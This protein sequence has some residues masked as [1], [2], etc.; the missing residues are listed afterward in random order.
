MN[1]ENN[2]RL[3]RL[4]PNGLTLGRL[5]LTVVFL[6]MVLYAP[7]KSQEK[8]ATFLMVAFTLFVVAGVTDMVDGPVAR[9]LN[10][11]S[12]FGRMVDP[13]ADKILVGGAFI[14]FAIVKQPT[15]LNIFS[16][17]TASVIQWATAIIIIAREVLVTILRHIA[18]ARGVSFAATATGKIKMFVQSFGIGTVMVKWAFVSRSW[19]DWFTVVTFLIMLTVT[20]VS[21]VSSLRRPRG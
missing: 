8:P 11:T 4:I 16:P 1:G 21:G 13:L 12:K 5:I 6:V 20:V 17:I 7:Q 15:F 3:V 18:E 10:V 2:N 9:A 14:C 19:G